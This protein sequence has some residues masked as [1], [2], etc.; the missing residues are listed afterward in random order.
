KQGDKELAYKNWLPLA[1]QG[2]ARAQFFLSVL[3]EQWTGSVEDRKNTKRWL[4]A[5][6]NN[7]FIPAQFNL[8]NNYHL[9]QYGRASNK[10][11][12][13]WWQQAA[14][15][16]FVEAQ[17]YLGAIYYWGEGIELDLKESF[18]WFD[19]AAKSG[20]QRAR[21]ALLQVR[22]GSLERDKT[23]PVNIAYDDPRIVSRL[24]AIDTDNT[25]SPV[26]SDSTPDQ[27]EVAAVS[28]PS[29]VDDVQGQGEA[30]PA[31]EQNKLMQPGE[32]QGIG[33]TP[34]QQPGPE[35]NWV[36]QQPAESHTIQLFAS[37]RMQHCEDYV[38]E[39]RHSYRL[40]AHAYA[41]SLK[42]RKLCAVV[43]GSYP[44]LS[45]AMASMR[46]LPPKLRESKPWIRTLGKLRRLAR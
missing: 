45:E 36:E 42:H 31:L 43:Y 12:A 24:S 17:Y 2:D 32:E 44:K 38:G 39:L 3:Y 4:T 6:A 20:S 14:I 35:L 41:F 10:M 26:T 9:G 23:G 33:P 16:G 7:G 40:Q 29:A 8:G 37:G 13:H 21:A 25:E 1:I 18:Y 27:P 19:K 30:A 46:Q 22:A 15:Q 34:V 11:A 5:S 28:G